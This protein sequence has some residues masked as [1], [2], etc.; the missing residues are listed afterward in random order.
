MPM[1]GAATA[2]SVIERVELLASERLP[3]DQARLLCRFVRA[4]LER[5]ATHRGWLLLSAAVMANHVHLVV[6]VVGDPDP[7]TLLRD[8]KAYAS[9]ALNRRWPKPAAGT[10]WTESGSKRKKADDAA[11]RGAVEYVR[12][13]P[14]PLAV[15][16]D[17]VTVRQVL[18]EPGA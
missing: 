15:W 13:Q 18:G 2:R 3:A 8:F 14:N 4:Y 16:V 17:D 10:W 12:D 9:R 1:S 7:E 6:G 5:V 11:A